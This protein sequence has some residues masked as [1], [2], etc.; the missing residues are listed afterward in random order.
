MTLDFDDVR[1]RT[2]PFDGGG[3]R[4]WMVEQKG[5]PRPYR[6]LVDG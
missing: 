6:R 4:G 3:P 5:I 1:R 2:E